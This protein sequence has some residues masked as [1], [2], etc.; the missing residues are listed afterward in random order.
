MQCNGG[1]KTYAEKPTGKARIEKNQNHG[2]II[3]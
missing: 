2:N 3:N 1:P